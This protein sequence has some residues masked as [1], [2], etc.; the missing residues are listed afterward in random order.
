MTTRVLITLPDM[1]MWRASFGNGTFGMQL[2]EQFFVGAARLGR[3]ES[4]TERGG[5]QHAAYCPHNI[6]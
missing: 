5:A 2:T 3:S 4:A 6:H 1:R